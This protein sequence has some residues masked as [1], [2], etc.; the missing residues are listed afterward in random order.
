MEI[1]NIVFDMGGVIITLDAQRA[2]RRFEEIGLA[3]IRRFLDPYEQKGFFLQLE[4]GQLDAEGFRRELS[5]HAGKDI[6]Q[7]RVTYAWMGFMADVP[8]YKLDYLAALR[9]QYRVFVLSNTNPVVMPWLES[10]DFS[11]DG[12]PL[13]AFC[14]KAYTSFQIGYTKPDRRIFEFMLTDAAI[15]PSETLFVDDGERNIQAAAALGLHTCLVRNG[16]DWRPALK[17]SLISAYEH[18]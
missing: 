11:A 5:A 7:E 14:D 9:Q 10:S 4:N 2:V 16:E 1:K 8:Q 13:S 6:P 12:K 18:R 3:D 17:S 15:T